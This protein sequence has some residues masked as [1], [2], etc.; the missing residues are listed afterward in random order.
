TNTIVVVTRYFGGTKLG[1]GGLARAY[2]KSAA[3]CLTT[4]GIVR[5]IPGDI[6]KISTDYHN[7]GKIK[8]HLEKHSYHIIDEEYASRVI[9]MVLAPKEESEVLKT[10]LTDL[11]NATAEINK[12]GE[13]YIEAEG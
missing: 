8:N 6:M 12:V 9:I 3:A 4:A 5:H 2:S 1:V 10:K 7:L 11:T 13:R